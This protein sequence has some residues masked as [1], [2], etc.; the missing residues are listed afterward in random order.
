MSNY[1]IKRMRDKGMTWQQVADEMNEQ[2]G[3]DLT[4]SAYRMRISGTEPVKRQRLPKSKY[5]AVGSLPEFGSVLIIG[6]THLPFVHDEYLEFCQWVAAEYDCEGVVHI[7]DF[8]DLYAVSFWDHEPDTMGAGQ[9]AD[10]AEQMAQDWYNAF[11]EVYMCIGNHDARA[12][13]KAVSAGI[14]TRFMRT[15]EEVWGCP[16]GWQWALGWSGGGVNYTHG[17]GLGGKFP[18]MNA[19]KAHAC[20]IV[21]GHVHT[22]GGVSYM[23]LANGKSVFGMNVGCGIDYSSYA[24][25]YSRNSL[26]S[27]VM[28]CGVVME[29]GRAVFVPMG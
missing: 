24:Y 6:D 16:E 19:A 23:A 25:A 9:E 8:V 28:G 27:P 5:G 29:G 10:E 13:R 1:K 11:P 22:A 18:A 2:L 20:S 4:A 3:L 26:K 17:T 21:M 7:G 15:Y 14:P 12:Y